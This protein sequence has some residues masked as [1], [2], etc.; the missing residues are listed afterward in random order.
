MEHRS[1][2][3]VFDAPYNTVIHDLVQAHCCMGDNEGT[4]I[5]Q[6]LEFINN[7]KFRTFQSVCRSFSTGIKTDMTKEK[8]VSKVGDCD[9]R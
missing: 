6:P 9:S 1:A 8:L 7:Q 3:I 4:A 5:A 2:L